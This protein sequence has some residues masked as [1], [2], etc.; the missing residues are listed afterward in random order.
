MAPAGARPTQPG[1]AR[2]CCWRR[3]QQAGR[4]PP[5]ASVP[6]HLFLRPPARPPHGLLPAPAGDTSGASTAVPAAQS[7]SFLPS[8]RARPPPCAIVVGARRPSSP[9]GHSSARAHGPPPRPLPS[10]S[11]F[12]WLLAAS[13][14]GPSCCPGSVSVCACDAF[15]SSCQ[16]SPQSAHLLLCLFLRSQPVEQQSRVLRSHGWRSTC[17]GAESGRR[18]AQ[19]RS[20]SSSCL[21]G[22]R[23]THVSSRQQTT[24]CCQTLGCRGPAA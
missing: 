17:A 10:F 4:P 7:P 6:H 9:T 19:Q 24:A 22:R 12:S 21:L 15:S 3:W 14:R 2:G 11:S 13:L 16:P 5:P 18:S 23:A 8:A 1:S 20:P